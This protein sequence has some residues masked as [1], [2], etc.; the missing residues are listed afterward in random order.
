MVIVAILL[1]AVQIGLFAFTSVFIF[2]IPGHR[3]F[4]PALDQDNE[5]NINISTLLQY[6]PIDDE[7]MELSQCTRYHNISYNFSVNESQ[8]IGL[9]NTE[10]CIDGWVY[11]KEGGKTTGTIEF[12]LVCKNSW[13][14]ILLTFGFSLGAFLCGLAGGT[15]ADRFGRKTPTLIYGF[16]MSVVLIGY[17]YAQNF[18]HCVICFSLIGGLQT[19]SCNTAFVYVQE[20]IKT[21]HRAVVGCIFYA[22]ISTGY[23]LTSLIAY[24]CQDWRWIVRIIGLYGIL[25]IPC[26]WILVESPRWLV[27]K[28]RKEEATIILKCILAKD[29]SN[30]EIWNQQLSFV[31]RNDMEKHEESKNGPENV[32]QTQ[33]I[34]LAKNPILLKRCLIITWVMTVTLASYYAFGYN[35]SNLGGNKYLNSCISALVEIPGLMM[36]PLFLQK[37]GRRTTTS[38]AYALACL[39][40]I[41]CPLFGDYDNVSTAFAMLGKVFIASSLAMVF[42]YPVELFPTPL[43]NT[44]VGYCSALA[45][46]G[47][48][49]SPFIAFAG[50]AFK[51]VPFYILSST[52]LLAS[53]SILLLPETK[54][55]PLPETVRDSLEFEQYRLK[56]QCKKKDKI[57]REIVVEN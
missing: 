43:R 2:S 8:E 20:L 39:C 51:W 54:G 38:A 57:D 52:A 16:L 48:L 45:R 22:S 18:S 14:R 30:D 46:L 29:K 27:S 31:S 3:C 21:R 36:A 32:D 25:Y 53:I 19:V 33:F 35:T 1:N 23:M 5:S 11:S 56:L 42:L 13:Q 4:V 44:A 37:F 47:G 55:I 10:Y 24:L 12:D 26:C 9:N 50:E 17:S 7:T 6:I 49:L 40:S 28:G 41:L 15:I 34:T